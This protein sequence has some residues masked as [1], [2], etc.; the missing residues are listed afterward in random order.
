M[1]K[2]RLAKARFD[3]FL[4]GTITRNELQRLRRQR[5]NER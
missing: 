1:S 3:A 4:D 5:N 2:K